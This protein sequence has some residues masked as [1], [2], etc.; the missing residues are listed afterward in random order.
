MKMPNG[1]GNLIIAI[2]IAGLTVLLSVIMITTYSETGKTEERGGFSK[3]SS[4]VE[5]HAVEETGA[6]NLVSSIYLGYRAFDTLGETIVLVLV[7]SGAVMFI[8]RRT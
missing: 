1:I 8:G 4:Y 5:Q 7:V 6:V 3:Q 2:F